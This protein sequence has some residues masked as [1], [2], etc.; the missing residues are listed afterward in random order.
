MIRRTLLIAAFGLA[1]S[2]PAPAQS[3]PSSDRPIAS[4][5]VITPGGRRAERRWANRGVASYY[6]RSLHGRRTASGERYNH[7]AMTVAHKSLPFGTILRVEDPR[8]GR[9]IIVRVND[10]GPFIRGPRP[11]SLGRCRR[12]PPDAPTRHRPRQLRDR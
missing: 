8:S 7:N 2:G 11:G 12:P 3:A 6:A 4:Q 10:R 5:D 9:R 1:T